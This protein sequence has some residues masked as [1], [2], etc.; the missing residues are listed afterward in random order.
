MTLD[1]AKLCIRAGLAFGDAWEQ[2]DDHA[3]EELR[4]WYVRDPGVP[5]NPTRANRSTKPVGESGPLNGSA[6]ALNGQTKPTGQ[7]GARK[8]VPAITGEICKECQGMNVVRTGTCLTCQ[9]CGSTS[10]GCA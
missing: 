7:P 8:A 4:A 10:G 2:V 9:D 6:H 1:E 3:R 5:R